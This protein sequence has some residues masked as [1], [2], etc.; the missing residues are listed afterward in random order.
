MKLTELAPR[1]IRL[2]S[3]MEDVT[4]RKPDGS[5]GTENRRWWNFPSGHSRVHLLEVREEDI[6]LLE[7]VCEQFLCQRTEQVADRGQLRVVLPMAAHDLVEHRHETWGL[8]ADV[9]VVTAD[10]VADQLLGAGSGPVFR[11]RVFL[12]LRQQI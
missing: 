8:D 5:D 3:K 7:H 2:E 1:F 12:N 10:N 4:I 11:R 9:T 6:L